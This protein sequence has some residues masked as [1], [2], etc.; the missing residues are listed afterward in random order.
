MNAKA[1]ER[2]TLENGL[3]QAINRQEFLLHYQPRVD[4]ASGEITGM[5]ALVRW[6]HPVQGLLY[7]TKFIPWQRSLA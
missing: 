7:P 5:E 3:R 6:Q 4:L 2:L 1:L